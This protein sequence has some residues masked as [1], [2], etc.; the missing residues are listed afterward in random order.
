VCYPS[1][2]VHRPEIT[3]HHD[4]N[5]SQ[6]RQDTVHQPLNTVHHPPIT[7]PHPGHSTPSVILRISFLLAL[8]YNITIN[9]DARSYFMKKV[10]AVMMFVSLLV[11]GCSQS[12]DEQVELIISSAASLQHALNDI[13]EKFEKEHPHV[14]VYFNYGG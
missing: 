7:T 8:S 1:I 2:T 9:K 12:N 5:T 14:K 6:H 3:V 11:A 4:R 10:F 13:Q